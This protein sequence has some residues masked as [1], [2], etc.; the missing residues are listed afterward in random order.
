LG[1]F[2]D[3]EQTVDTLDGLRELGIPDSDIKVLSSLP[4]SSD[5]L[6]R[7]PI[8]SRLLVISLISAVVGLAVGIFLTVVTPYMYVIQVGGHPI[9]PVPPTALLLYE[10]TMLFLILGTFGGMLWQAAFPS[11][12]RQYY[13]PSLTDGRIG[14]LIHCFDDKKEAVRAILESQGAENVHQPERR[15][16]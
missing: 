4:Y 12:D 5:I 6:G 10:F 14:L 11:Y 3:I 9:V 16:L 7:P 2:Q 13:D 8:K 15:E 1:S